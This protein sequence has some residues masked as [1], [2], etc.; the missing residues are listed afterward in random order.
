MKLNN[1]RYSRI[2]Y[3]RNIQSIISAWENEYDEKKN[4]GKPAASGS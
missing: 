2:A 3:N 4:G 1:V